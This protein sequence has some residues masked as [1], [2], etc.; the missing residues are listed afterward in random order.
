MNSKA[1]YAPHGKHQELITGKDLSVLE[2]IVQDDNSKFAGFTLKVPD[3]IFDLGVY[4]YY[5]AGDRFES[6]EGVFYSRA[7]VNYSKDPMK[8]WESQL[9]FAVHCATSAIGDIYR[10]LKR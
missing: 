6:S 2:I 1:H 5:K 4:K 8:L 7:Q 10:A 9:N 3:A